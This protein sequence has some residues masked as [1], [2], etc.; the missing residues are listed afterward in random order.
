MIEKE[1]LAIYFGCRKHDNFLFGNTCYVFSDH[2][3]LA[4]IGKAAQH[5]IR[6][7]KYALLFQRYD[8]QICFRK[9]SAHGNAD[10]L[11]RVS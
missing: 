1:A 3:P 5:S 2:R 9:G 8:L 10:A 4:Y 11:T 6:I 7:A